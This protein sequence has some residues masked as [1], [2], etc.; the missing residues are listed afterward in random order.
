[1][2]NAISIDLEDW[3]CVHNLAGVI[4]LSDWDSCELRVRESTERLLAL[5]EQHQTRATFIVLGWV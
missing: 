3:F 1:M 2:K 4:K 5:F